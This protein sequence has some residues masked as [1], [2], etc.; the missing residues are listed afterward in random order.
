MIDLYIDSAALN[1]HDVYAE[2]E[3]ILKQITATVNG[4]LPSN[5][6]WHR[7]LLEHVGAND[8]QV[9]R[10]SVIYNRPKIN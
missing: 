9:P 2:V 10:P 5:S 1:L 6:E 8:K 4:R 7:D 3:R